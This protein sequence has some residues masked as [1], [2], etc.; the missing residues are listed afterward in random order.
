MRPDPKTVRETS[1]LMEAVA[2]MADGGFRH[3]PVVDENRRVVGIL[4]DRDLR[5]ALGDPLEALRSDREGLELLVADVMSVEVEKVT[6]NLPLVA[7]VELLTEDHFGALPVVDGEGRLAG[8][9]SYVDVLRELAHPRRREAAS[10]PA[11]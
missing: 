4:S 5:S 3:V 2:L 1:P 8:I 9:L 11:A 7:A 6:A 10:A